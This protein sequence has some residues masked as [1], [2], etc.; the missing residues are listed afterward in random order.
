[1]IDPYHNSDSIY[2]EVFDHEGKVRPHYQALVN[3][4]KSYDRKSFERLN[5]DAKLIFYNEGITFAVYS[6]NEATERIFP[7]DMVPRLITSKEWEELEAGVLQRNRAINAFLADIYNEQKILNEGI[8]PRALIESSENFVKE[9]MGVKPHGGVYNHISGSDIIRHSDGSFYVLED[10]VRCPSGISYV[11]ANRQTLKKTFPS[12][13]ENYR[14]RQVN[15]Y[16]SKLLQM[17]QT[18]APEGVENP[19]CVVL[20]PGVYN[21]AYYEHAYL[22][23]SMGVE[24]VEGRDMFVKNN[25]VYAKTIYGSQRVDVIYRRID[26]PFIDP[27]VFRKDSMLGVNGLMKAYQEGNVTLVNAPGTGVSDD[28]AVYTFMPEIIKYYLDQEPILKNVPTY[29]C[30][31]DEDYE[32]VMANIDKLV[33]KPVDESGG[34]GI[35]IGTTLSKPEI[36]VVQKNISANRRKYI[37]QPIMSLSS[38]P[39]FINDNGQMEGRYLDLRTFCLM[40]KNFEYVVP[41]G[42]TR[43]ALKKGN[44]IVNSSQGGGSKDTWVID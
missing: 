1:M 42:L 7:F 23:Q 21:S 2:D 22:A 32:Y 25:V 34:Y 28:K 4:F 44:L 41:G 38:H 5:E 30:E 18:V 20:T 17:M 40:G 3:H 43:V 16:S 6:N 15:N 31:I 19:N 11:V 36:G 37:A 29:K 14:T 13:F 33:V 10:N 8:V 26:D 27:E 39:T 35:T 12:L 24:L 9:M